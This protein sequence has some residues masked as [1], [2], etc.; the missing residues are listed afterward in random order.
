MSLLDRVAVVGSRGQL[1]IDVMEAFGD[2]RPVALNRPLFDLEVGSSLLG[3][4]EAHRPTLVI[5]TAAFHDVEICEAQPARAFAVNAL[6]VDA[7]AASCAAV[8][9][10]LMHVSTDYVFDG[11]VQEPYPEWAATAPLNAYAASK[12]AGEHLLRRHGPAWFV[13]RTCGLYG[14]A[15]SRVKGTTFAETML[16]KAGAGE[17]I[18]VV[19]D[20]HVA[21]S[22]TRDVARAMRAVA[23][24]GRFGTYH[25]TNAGSCTWFEFAA[26]IFRLAGL[27]G[28]RLEQVSS[29]AF[30]TYARRP[31]YSVLSHEGLEA[32][33]Y[34]MPP[35]QEGLRD[36]LMAKGLLTGA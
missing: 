7:L 25:V 32:I 34:G 36:Y 35:W 3:A 20:Q 14:V 16:R 30:F 13:V 19:G 18:R 31:A 22:Y 24:S 11:A 6:G 17:T 12:V 8:G 27:T 23:E 1:G 9:A 15:G 29:D 33:G 4:L 28:V 10:A 5:N 21:P 2:L 26:E